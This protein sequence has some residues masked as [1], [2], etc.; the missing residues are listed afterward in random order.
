MDYKS[1]LGVL[2][3]AAILAGCGNI[4]YLNEGELLY[5]GGEVEVEG[6][7]IGRTER[8]YLVSNMEGMLR[9]RPNTS[10]LGLRPQL[11]FYNIAGGEE[12]KGA[13]NRWIRDNLGEPPVL[14]REVDLDYNA[15]L[16]Q[17][18]AEN[19]GYFNARAIPDSTEKNKKVTA[20]YTVD[21]RNRYH[22]KEVNF[23]KDSIPLTV[24]IKKTEERSLLKEGDP[25]MLSVV[26]DERSRIDAN[27]KEE[28]F[29][30]FRPD[31]LLA[32]VDSTAG[33]HQVTMDLTLKEETP[34]RA[35]EQY[36]IGNIYIYPNYSISGDTIP[37]T[38]AVAEPYENFT[39]INPER[40]FKPGLFERSL[41]F[42]KGELYNRT[43]H[44][45]SLN[46]LVNLGIFRFVNNQF[47]VVDTAENVLDAYYYLTPMQKKSIRLETIA[48]TNSANFAGTELNLSW[49]NRNTFG[50][51][52][53]LRISAFGAYE[54]QISG[55][56]KG[57]NV[58]RL[59]TETS[60]TWPR[61]IAPFNVP[62]QSAFV[63]RT[64]AS[65]S[66]EYQAREALYGLNSFRGT[67][68]YLWKDNIRVEHRLDL[69]DI[70]YV[71]PFN[72]TDLYRDQI[73]LNPMLGRIIEEQLIFGPN[74]TYTFTNTMETRR[75]HRFFYQG[76]I[77]LSGNVTGLITGADRE[78]GD[79]KEIFGVPFSQYVRLDNDVRHYLDMGPGLELASRVMVGAG[80][81]YGN[82]RELPFIKQFFVGGVN[83]VRA[84]RAR[85]VGPGTYFE[86]V[87]PTTFL[88]DQSGDLRLEMNTE[89]RAK[90]FSIVEG[91]AFVDA[92]N[93]WLMNEDPNRPGA[94]LTGDFL[95]ELAV[96]TG[97]GIRLDLSFLILRLDLA[98]PIRLPYLPEGNRWVFDQIDF[99]SS[100]WRRQNLV[101]N[102]AIGYP[103]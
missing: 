102:L 78:G 13:I 74:Y 10:I 94:E 51:A 2:F 8:K 25:Y 58:F 40:N 59:G 26:R 87:P 77:D 95:K 22:L 43:D 99:S 79:V 21:L 31:Y 64:R 75:K 19:R 72:V 100:A 11:W 70:N 32:Q 101:F 88:P 97:V 67:W 92:G 103:F 37:I 28:G 98:F 62:S 4:K 86:E 30:F 7:D 61:I 66:Y 12:A 35:K 46:R 45:K 65:L 56:N 50:A 73:A 81:P 76:N 18:Y 47:K 80:L 33:N 71:N 52:E 1:L 93:V 89:L 34:S 41:L 96:G 54:F 3:M 90:L 5:V 20:E 16:I 38:S 55:L 91:A 29:Y 83:S 69:M 68:S 60:L 44:N 14:F 49:S 17:G 15:S 63:P 84:F 9:P 23:P 85:S 39:I 57:F 36:R 53:L 24:A 42:E 27:L 6:E 82:S 48:K